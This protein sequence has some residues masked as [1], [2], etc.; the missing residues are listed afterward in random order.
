L[1][2]GLGIA[3]G[4]LGIATVA[5]VGRP[6]LGLAV[7]VGAE[8][9]GAGLLHPG[10]ALLLLGVVEVSNASEVVGKHAGLS[11]HVLT[12]AVAAASLGLAW[13]RRA[14]EFP[15]SPV[16]LFAVVFLAGRALS[17]LA[18]R[19]VPTG[20]AVVVDTVD[21]VVFLFLVATLL[22]S[23]KR[24]AG[25]SAAV[26]LAVSLLAGL[27][28]M[29]EFVFHNRT[30]FAGFSQVPLEADLGGATARHSGPQ[31]DANLWGRTLVIFVPLALSLWADRGTGRRRWLWL[32]AVALLGCGEYLTQSRGGMIALAASVT[33]WLA[34]AGR[35]YARTLLVA[36]LLVL[37]LLT[38][39]GVGSRLSTL[40][41]LEEAG[42]GGGDQSLVGRVVA[43]RS[44]L[45]MFVDHPA[46]GVGAGNFE[47][48][49]PDY[50]RRLGFPTSKALAPHNVYLQ[51][52]A[53]A[54]VVGL[55]AWILFL[56]SG[57]FVAG[58]ALILSRHLHRGPPP[59]PA[60]LLAVAALAALAGWA[61]ASLF[62]DLAH[63]R[64][65]MLVIGLAAA[66]DVE[67]R[68]AARALRA[69][70]HRAGRVTEGVEGGE[71]IA[72]PARPAR[73]LLP[74]TRP[75]RLAVAALGFVVA[76][77]GG[78]NF[79]PLAGPAWVA[80]ASAVVA[81]VEGAPPVDNA[82][83]YDVLTRGPVMA[84]YEAIVGHSRF[85]AEA[86]RELGLHAAERESVRVEVEA[87]P[88][89]SVIT[90]SATGDR[91]GVVRGMAQRT[92]ERARRYIDSA[93]R[94][95][96][97]GSAGPPSVSRI[98]AAGLAG[99]LGIVALSAVVALLVY[100]VSGRIGAGAPGG[101]HR[102]GRQG[103]RGPWTAPAQML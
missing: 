49:E 84:T 23:T 74:G 39:P 2:A 48:V 54:G 21:Q 16:L 42:A 92:L 101:R 90:V 96:V 60:S 95:Y 77:G 14:V 35:R 70:D 83:H 99:R 19:D 37:V 64:V 63:G 78:L 20:L 27:S 68:S 12:V 53:E 1:S 94:L 34:L 51:M 88:T 7:L 100:G 55:A 26:V 102:A 87:S 50:A 52:A 36:P 85:T 98:G 15:S 13:R 45:A 5:V 41:D 79:V 46:I 73:P 43:Q 75:A 29:Q 86:A 17:L 67:A 66:L 18:A 81:P 44:G 28:V 8:V 97:I 89:S 38:I 24:F 31:N 3:A 40:T 11:L 69:R 57:W 47:L 76:L 10:V 33:V 82:Y 71:P 30:T 25:F 80:R 6:L 62:L 22:C 65:L 58:R 72:P 4:S 59:S 32:G 56:G 91:P 93:P 9:I 103:R 61:L